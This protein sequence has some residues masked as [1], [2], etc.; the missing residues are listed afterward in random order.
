MAKEIILTE[1]KRRI[2]TRCKTATCGKENK[3]ASRKECLDSKVFKKD[4]NRNSQGRVDV[5]GLQALV[6]SP[7]DAPAT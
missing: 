7:E 3:Q 5:Q 1:L 2:G 6:L 4:L